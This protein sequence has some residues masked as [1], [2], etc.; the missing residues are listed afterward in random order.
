VTVTV[1]DAAGNSRS[2]TEAI[3]VQVNSVISPVSPDLTV[4][5]STVADPLPATVVAEPVRL[6]DATKPGPVTVVEDIRSLVGAAPIYAVYTSPGVDAIQIPVMK[7]DVAA[8]YVFKGVPDQSF[9]QGSHIR[10]RLPP[11]A[12]MH[13]NENEMVRVYA[14]RTDGTQLPNW[15]HFN[16]TAGEFDGD[17][18]VGAPPEMEV[19]VTARDAAGREASA[20]FRLKLRAGESVRTP[21]RVG[22]VDKLRAAGRQSALLDSKLGA[23]ERNPMKRVA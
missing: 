7:A 4:P 16:S 22:L 21:G 9:D 11:D 19:R 18:P 2:S 14:E 8:I 6:P 3:G 13:T 20:T 17:V 10:F 15:L 23:H 12:F 5:P 1:A